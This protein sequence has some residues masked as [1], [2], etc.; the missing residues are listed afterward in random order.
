MTDIT[1]SH[2]PTVR[3]ARIA[4]AGVLLAVTVLGAACGDDSTDT[5][6]EGGASGTS[7][8]TRHDDDEATGD[9]AG[10]TDDGGDEPAPAVDGV[11]KECS[12]FPFAMEPADPDEITMTPDGWPAPPPGATLCVTSATIGGSTEIAEYA[13]GA[14]PETILGYYEAQL[15]EGFNLS[16]EAG[17]GAEMLTGY[18]ESV[19][20][21]ISTRDGGFKIAFGEL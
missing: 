5:A 14:E 3:R 20:F 12:I 2:V 15:G 13:L 9:G 4:F 16:R 19:G 21:Q 1:D 11:P 10:P 7:E 6:S 17:V 8:H 18:D